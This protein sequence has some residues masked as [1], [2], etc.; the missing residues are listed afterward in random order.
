MKKTISTEKI[1][2]QI[3]KRKELITI[4]LIVL[5]IAGMTY[6][7]YKAIN[8]GVNSEVVTK[9]EVQLESLNIN[10]DSKALKELKEEKAPSVING[11]A[12]RNPF[13][14]L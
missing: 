6:A 9:G 10:F 8:P 13:T 7:S 2:A 12:G 11:V 3:V 14:P 4:I 5:F 1:K